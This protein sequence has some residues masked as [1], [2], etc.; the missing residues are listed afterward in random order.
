MVSAEEALIAVRE[1][2]LWKK[3]KSPQAPAPTKT[4]VVVT[5]QKRCCDRKDSAWPGVPLR[6]DR[7]LSGGGVWGGVFVH[8]HL[9]AAEVQPTV[10][11]RRGRWTCC[12]RR[13]LTSGPRLL[14]FCT[15]QPVSQEGGSAGAILT[16]ARCTLWH[17]N[18]HSSLVSSPV[19][20]PTVMLP[21][22]VCPHGRQSWRVTGERALRFP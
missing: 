2:F 22:Q 12:A 4:T 3:S 19:A 16:H 6:C 13:H 1:P 7:R 11:M 14:V 18:A 8:N 21:H 20:P 17:P 5:T 15:A 10:R 9:R